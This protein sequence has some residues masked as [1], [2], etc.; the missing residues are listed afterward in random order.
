M[1]RKKKTAL[2]VMPR[3]S[4][5]WRGSEALW[6]TVGGWAKAAEKKFGK[7]YIFTTDRVASSDEVLEYPLIPSSK[8]QSNPILKKIIKKVP[9]LLTV[10]IKDILLLKSS[11]N[12]G[13]Y[14]YHFPEIRDEVAMVWE[15]HDF[16]P[17]KGYELAKKYKAPFII[18]VHAPQVWES[19]K[20]GVKRPG[21]GR[22]LEKLEIRALSRAD[23]VACVSE[24]VAKKIQQMGVPKEK[25]KVSPMGVNVD[26]FKNIDSS[27]IIEKYS[28]EDKFVIGWTGSFRS[29]HG[30]DILI[31]VF[32]QVSDKIE[33]SRLML[34]GDG[35][36][37]KNMEKLA[38]ELGIYEQVIFCGRKTFTE[39]PK[40]VNIFD[41]A[42]VS[43][44]RNTNFHYSPLKLREFL[45][46]GIA[47]LA[48]NAGEIP[49]IFKD[50]IHLK[51]YTVGEITETAETIIDLAKSPKK[52]KELGRNGK[53]FI[54]ENAT[55]EVELNKVIE[56]LN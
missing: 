7:A 29:F 49:E 22:I 48:P 25:I 16:F 1:E 4:M 31:K 26:I 56:S 47:T 42:I 23:V 14:N 45:A 18:Y 50:N 6:I 20:W 21:W 27:N 8:T 24:K 54:K 37:K 13:N 52:R 32:K 53:L 51:L 15:Q 30:L 36:E 19:S 35:F 17:G 9:K 11:V 44:S 43:T 28:L 33:N 2:F 38:T 55:W 39:I 10:F 46:A 12:K 5:A 34:V 41:L 40:F 3:S